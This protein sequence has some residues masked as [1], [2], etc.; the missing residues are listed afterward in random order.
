MPQDTTR[1]NHELEVGQSDR[2]EHNSLPSVWKNGTRL[3]TKNGKL[4]GAWASSPWPKF[5]F[6]HA[7]RELHLLIV[8][9]LRFD[10]THLLKHVYQIPSHETDGHHPSLLTHPCVVIQT[11]CCPHSLLSR[12]GKLRGWHAPFITDIRC[13]TTG[14]L[15]RQTAASR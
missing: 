10:R 4:A 7:N 2:H 9:N 13:S 15:T 14:S 8:T 12:K 5:G 11:E 1:C 3:I 6:Q